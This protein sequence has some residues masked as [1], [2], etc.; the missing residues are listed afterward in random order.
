M[1]YSFFFNTT[2]TLGT[3]NKQLIL[4]QLILLTV[5]HINDSV[6]SKFISVTMSVTVI[7]GV[8]AMQ[9]L[10]NNSIIIRLPKIISQ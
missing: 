4:L 5:V 8:L 2:Y 3:H 6:F 1:F 9:E 10:V 7:M